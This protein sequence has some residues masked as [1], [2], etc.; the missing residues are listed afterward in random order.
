MN[1][2]L[3]KRKNIIKLNEYP[4]AYNRVFDYNTRE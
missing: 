1:L 2:E 3:Y 4:Q